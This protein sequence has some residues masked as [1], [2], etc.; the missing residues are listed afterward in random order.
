MQIYLC[1]GPRIGHGV[2]MFQLYA[3]MSAYVVQSVMRKAETS[4]RPLHRTNEGKAWRGE[5]VERTAPAEHTAVEAGIMRHQ[6][7]SALHEGGELRPQLGK[8][9]LI[10]EHFDKEQITMRVGDRRVLRGRRP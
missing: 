10:L 8:G 5:S 1:G 6:K 4:P 7:L 9:R 3:E 2:M